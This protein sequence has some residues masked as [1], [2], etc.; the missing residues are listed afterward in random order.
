MNQV[1]TAK[2]NEELPPAEDG[3]FIHGWFTLV[4]PSNGASAIIKK[5]VRHAGQ[6]KPIT[7]DDVLKKLKKLK[8]IHG[9][10]MD[11]IHEL[12]KSVNNNIIPDQEIIIARSDV[13]HGENGTLKWLIQGL[14][15]NS[16]DICLAPNTKIAVRKLATKGKP[17]KNVFGKRVNPRAGFDQQLEAGEGISVTAGEDNEFFYQPKYIGLLKYD[18]NTLSLDPRLRIS[19]DKLQ[20]HMDIQG[21]LEGDV[22]ISVDDILATISTYGIKQ[23]IIEENISKALAK[24]YKTKNAIKNVLIAE[25]KDPVHGQDAILDWQFQIKNKSEILRA[26]LPNDL[27]VT[28]IPE[29]ENKSGFNIYAEVLTAKIGMTHSMNSEAGILK[30]EANGKTEYRAQWLGVVQY[31]SGTLSTIPDIE[32]SEDNMEVSMG[33]YTKVS[34][35]EDGDI[36]YEHVLHTLMEH[37]IKFGIKANE[38]KASLNKARQ[39]DRTHFRMIVAEGKQPQDGVNAK[40]VIDDRIS[41]G[42]LLTNGTID[43]HEKSYPWDIK[44]NGIIGHV[45]PRKAEIN[46]KTVTGEIIQA[47]AA[48]ELKLILDGVKQGNDGKLRAAIDGV[49]LVNGLNITV[50]EN[51]VINGDIDTNTG[52]ISTDTTVIVNGYVKPGFVV[53]ARKGD[54]IIQE[55]IEDAFV[56]ARGSIVIKA[57]IRGSRS[58]VAAAGNISTTFAENTKLMVN[59][60]IAVSNNI[61]SCNIYCKGNLTVGD[62]HSAKSTLIGGITRVK[63]CLAAANLGSEG[64]VKTVIHMGP[65]TGILR[66]YKKIKKE[67]EVKKQ[68]LDDLQR[69]YKHYEQ[70]PGDNKEAVLKKITSTSENKLKEFKKIQINYNYLHDQINEAGKAKVVI[71]KHVYPGVFIHLMNQTYEVNEKRNAGTFRLEG[72]LLIFD[73]A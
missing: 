14:D 11:V 27:I 22:K 37:G 33:L 65:S 13:V 35:R 18:S 41:T 8:V 73:P 53:K 50:S 29:T 24:A 25:G 32:I 61:I 58:E 46:G 72:G 28:H 39:D 67:F 36:T 6:G 7:A 44:T 20:A 17:G 19:D 45:I 5:I 38:I 30:K 68:E 10:D 34:Y 23:G 51:V 3:P 54:V 49:L 55:N 47:I 71:H 60:D 43:Y 40:L 16:S 66:Q 15:S 63:K 70:E 48:E 1:N 21:L 26:V 69:L 57:G 64:C 52:N 62:A 42:K 12:L 4:V 31:E 9:I 56:Y 2:L 59:K